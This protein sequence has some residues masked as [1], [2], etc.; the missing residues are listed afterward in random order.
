M[1]KR[2]ALW[3]WRHIASC[4]VGGAY[5][6]PRIGCGFFTSCVSA[7]VDRKGW[8]MQ[9]AKLWMSRG[10][11]ETTS[12]AVVDDD[13]V[14]NNHDSWLMINDYDSIVIHQIFF[15]TRGLTGLSSLLHRCLLR[16]FL[17]CMYAVSDKTYSSGKGATAGFEHPER[18]LGKPGKRAPGVKKCCLCCSKFGDCPVVTALTALGLVGVVEMLP[19]VALVLSSMHVCQRCTLPCTAQWW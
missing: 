10:R 11:S 13:Y 3:R 7:A 12:T 16:L 17:L 18:A 14:D 4:T 2:C 1:C 9:T 5:S 19:N 15:Y 6:Q 8:Q